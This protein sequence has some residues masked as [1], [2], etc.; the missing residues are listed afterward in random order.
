MGK[1]PSGTGERVYEAVKGLKI[2]FAIFG[3]ADRVL[4]HPKIVVCTAD[5]MYGIGRRPDARMPLRG[6]RRGRVAQAA[7]RMG[8]VSSGIGKGAYEAV[9]GLKIDLTIFDGFDWRSETG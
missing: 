4:D 1:A 6:L 3:G 5:R 7:L 8:K 9:R 2:D